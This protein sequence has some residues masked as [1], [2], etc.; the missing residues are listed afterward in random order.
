MPSI[1][2]YCACGI[3]DITGIGGWAVC[4][5]G[6]CIYCAM[7]HQAFGRPRNAHL[8]PSLTCTYFCAHD[9]RWAS[10][11]ARSFVCIGFAPRNFKKASADRPIFCLP[12]LRQGISHDFQ[13]H[14]LVVSWYKSRRCWM[15]KN[16]CI[17]RNWL[18]TR[19]G[20]KGIGFCGISSKV[21]CVQRREPK[22]PPIVFR[23]SSYFPVRVL[24]NRK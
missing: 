13:A 14:L 1:R 4:F 18:C 15:A 8:R 17:H 21:T 6:A 16:E 10:L 7:V 3:C 22:L 23:T 5:R 12:R 24:W 9:R 20:C 2:W 11:P 19:I